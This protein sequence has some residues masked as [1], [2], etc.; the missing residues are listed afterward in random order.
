MLLDPTRSKFNPNLIKILV[1]YRLPMGSWSGIGTSTIFI[2]S[3]INVERWEFFPISRQRW[4]RPL[5]K[6]GK[7]PRKWNKR[8]SQR[9]WSPNNQIEAN[10][11]T[12]AAGAICMCV[13]ENLLK[14]M[15]IDT[16]KGCNCILN[17]KWIPVPCFEGLVSSAQA[18]EMFEHSREHNYIYTPYEVP[19]GP[20]RNGCNLLSLILFSLLLLFSNEREL[21]S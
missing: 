11:S 19:L 12:N 16:D 18:H 21:W 1:S 17:L 2:L 7:G 14:S 6:L 4:A 9:A 13:S 5:Q 15:T 20:V 10:T 3:C 8:H